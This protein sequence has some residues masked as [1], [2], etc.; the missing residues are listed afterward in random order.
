MSHFASHPLP[1]EEQQVEAPSAPEGPGIHVE[2]QRS[3]EKQ[4]VHAESAAG[5]FPQGSRLSLELKGSSQGAVLPAAHAA[6][7]PY[8]GMALQQ[9]LTPDT[10]A[11]LAQAQ[12]LMAAIEAA[13][14]AATP[15]SLPVG[16]V[17]LAQPPPSP[18][19]ARS[20]EPVSQPAAPPF[21]QQL[22]LPKFSSA[23]SF[24]STTQECPRRAHAD[25]VADDTRRGMC[26]DLAF[27]LEDAE[28]PQA[29][30]KTLEAEGVRTMSDFA[31][32]APSYDQ[33]DMLMN[34]TLKFG[35]SIPERLALSRLMAGWLTASK[36]VEAHRE[37]KATTKAHG[38]T[39]EMKRSD[40]LVLV[41]AL[42]R[43]RG[44]ALLTISFQVDAPLRPSLNRLRMG[45]SMLALWQ[46]SSV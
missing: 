40:Y 22:P 35:D 26:A 28:V 23:T 20:Q 43:V 30:I 10:M 4:S 25:P 5:G 13:Q 36:E 14:G 31:Y 2:A 32:L 38:E 16:S 1:Q 19:A 11:L 18:T 34:R 37:A 44:G 3:L 27:L 6:A 9:L 17:S 7:N 39:L 41:E 42:E 33:M 15:A 45:S 8:T 46:N 12:Q 24:T 29:V 21:Q